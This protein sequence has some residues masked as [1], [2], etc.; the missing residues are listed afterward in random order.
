MSENELAEW[1]YYFS[2]V[3]TD[4]NMIVHHIAQQTAVQ[5]QAKGHKNTKMSDFIISY[6]AKEDVEKPVDI[7]AK[8]LQQIQGEL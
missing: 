2:V 5:L 4:A 6:D 3:P 1:R 7:K 8:L